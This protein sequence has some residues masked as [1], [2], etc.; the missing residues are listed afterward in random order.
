DR[1]LDRDARRRRELQQVVAGAEADRGPAAA[2]NGAGIDDRIGIV[3]EGDG[4]VTGYRAG[5][6]DSAGAAVDAKRRVRSARTSDTRSTR[7]VDCSA[8]AQCDTGTVGA[9]DRTGVD[10]S[11]A[12]L[13][14]ADAVRADDFVGIGDGTVA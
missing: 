1:A 3:A 8:G 9:D 6:G 2:D 13:A 5:I 7:I 10:D 14:G 4:G 11:G 12:V